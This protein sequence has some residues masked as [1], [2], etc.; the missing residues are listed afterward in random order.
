MHSFVNDDHD[1]LTRETHYRDNRHFLHPWEDLGLLG[2]NERTVAAGGEGIYLNDS[3]GNKLID[4]PGGMWCNQIG[5]GR[6]EMAD[7]IA[8]QV[9]ELPYFS[10]FNLTGD[11]ST[12]SRGKTRQPCTR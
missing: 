6:Q 10:P 12:H 1:F 8:R 4:G 2:Q 5:Y 9:L 3:L 11:V 7:A